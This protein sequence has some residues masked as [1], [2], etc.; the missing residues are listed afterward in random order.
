MSKEVKLPQQTE[1]VSG[2]LPNFTDNWKVMTTDPVTLDAVTGLTIPFKYL[3]PCRI[4]TQEEL[5][6]QDVDPVVDAAVAELLTLKAAVIVPANTPGFYSR[7][8]TVPKVERGVEYGRRFI[9]NLKVSFVI[10]MVSMSLV[11]SRQKLSR[12]LEFLHIFMPTLN[13]VGDTIGY[14]S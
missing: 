10:K 5:A 9:I 14:T 7:V 4:P 8:F 11:L 2:A 12:V 3:P 6:R 13:P 1:F